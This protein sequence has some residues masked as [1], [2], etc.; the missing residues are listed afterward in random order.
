[1][2]GEFSDNKQT[3]IIYKVIVVTEP[4]TH[5]TWAEEADA[6][7]HVINSKTQSLTISK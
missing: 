2:N 3:V 7:D 6:K 4:P 5:E 1:M